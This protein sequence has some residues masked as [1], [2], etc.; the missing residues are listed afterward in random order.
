MRKLLHPI[1]G[2]FKHD[3]LFDGSKVHALATT[4]APPPEEVFA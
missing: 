4:P 3:P 1:Y 2:V